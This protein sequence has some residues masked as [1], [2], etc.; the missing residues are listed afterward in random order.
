MSSQNTT[1]G[2]E[3]T[4]ST[5]LTTGG[6]ITI[7]ANPALF[8]ISDGEGYVVDNYTD[9]QNAV[10]T[11]VNWSGLTEI[12][13]TNLATDPFTFIAINLSGSV[14]QQAKVFTDSQ[15]RD[16]IVL[17]LI[18]HTDNIAI[19]DVMHNPNT[20]FDLTLQVSD[21]LKAL[22]AV[23]TSG[24]IFTANGTN[25]SVDRS[26]GTIFRIGSNYAI[27][28]KNP[29]TQSIA[30]AT[31]QIMHPQYQDGSGDYITEPSVTTVDV[32]QFDDGSGTLATVPNNSRWQA[33]RIWVVDAETVAIVYGQNTFQDMAA[34]EASITLEDFNTSP[35]TSTLGVVRCFLI[36][37][38]ATTDLS[39]PIQ[40]KFLTPSSLASS[41]STGG[42]GG[43]SDPTASQ[44][45]TTLNNGGILSINTGTTFDIEDG[46]GWVVNNYTDP[47]N[48]V[49]TK[50][51][52]SSLTNIT[53][54]NIGTQ[55]RTFIAINSAGV[56][57]QQA[58]DF[59]PPQRRDL[60]IL[61]VVLHSDQI[62]IANV[63][64]APIT[65]FDLDSQFVDFIKNVVGTANL[66]GNV[67]SANAGGNL[68]F[69]RS[70]GQVFR[71]GANYEVDKQSPSISTDA[72]ASPQSFILRVRDG[73]GGFDLTGGQT[74]VIPANWDDGS[75]VLQTV[76][77]N[78]W[79]VMR[80]FIFNDGVT[81]L[82]YGQ[83]EYTNLSSAQSGVLTEQ[84]E[85]DPVLV[86]NAVLRCY[87]IVRGGALDLTLA[88][89]ANFIEANRFGTVPAGGTGSGTTTLQQAYLNSVAPQI[90]LDAGE[91]GLDY[92]DNAAPLG[93]TLFSISSNDGATKYLEVDAT[94][95]VELN[96]RVNL[97]Q[98]D[99]A[100][101]A[102]I[103]YT[104]VSNTSQYFKITFTSDCT[105][106]FTFPSGEV[107]SIALELINGG[108]FAVVWPIGVQWV[109]GVEPTLTVAGK[110]VIVIWQNGD[111]VVY[112]SVTGQNFS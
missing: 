54:T 30:S 55:P 112:G 28:K 99:V 61:G 84:F 73:V 36:V 75:G 65:R 14:I 42:V 58:T 100:A 97:N 20:R 4:E 25:L 82:Q 19:E 22:G 32:G 49:V 87:L 5:G 70:A 43:T 110:D 16:L 10:K 46:N 72:S 81:T 6:V 109:E 105:L 63:S 27:D 39:D 52:W 98:V 34:A 48:P 106:A 77:A 69:D 1:G 3:S 29:S 96:R 41:S 13:L 60:I 50:V 103:T 12:T 38:N 47:N 7:N 94:G 89:D 18:F 92:R 107:T 76:S 80:I 104:Q 26:A 9:P 51:T 53:V 66:A 23:N 44:L 93:T 83:A 68:S 101:N 90:I 11:K 33:Q 74:V 59:T 86:E 8:D 40:A 95:I 64:T 57:I 88:G 91:G 21:F 67:I 102:D 62:A 37:S 71:F 35:V 85:T 45:T 17:G 78:N 108:A 15:E 79:S 31:V 56:V 24:N 111:D 2:A